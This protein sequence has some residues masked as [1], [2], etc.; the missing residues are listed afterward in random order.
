MSTMR[1]QKLCYYSQ[2][3][4]LVWD[5]SPLFREDFQARANGSVCLKL[6]YKIQGKYSVIASDKT[7]V[8]RS[9]LNHT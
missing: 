8:C 9:Y 1:L 3:W 5:G 6:F 4:S 2:A 7:G